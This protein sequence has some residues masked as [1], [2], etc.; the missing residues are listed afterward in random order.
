MQVTTIQ[1][2]S[3]ASSTG[4]PPI[5][6][7]IREEDEEK[8]PPDDVFE[9]DKKQEAEKGKEGVAEEG[10]SHGTTYALTFI[11]RGNR[12]NLGQQVDFH[13]GHNW[14]CCRTR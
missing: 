13:L 8:E 7:G 10:I 12:R 14:V 3:V 6:G 1:A 5:E 9:D 2:D 11:F 4:L